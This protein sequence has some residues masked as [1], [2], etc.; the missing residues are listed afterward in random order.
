MDIPRTP[1]ADSDAVVSIGFQRLPYGGTQRG[2]LVVEWTNGGVYVYEGVPH[3]MY[4][5]L[6][7]AKSKGGYMNRK[8]KPIYTGRLLVD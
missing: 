8:V 4:D 1:V 3:W 5:E 7:M 2:T 6:M